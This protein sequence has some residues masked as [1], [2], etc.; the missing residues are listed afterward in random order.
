MSTPTG[1]FS[2]ELAIDGGVPVR[3][4]PLP[5][6]V[7]VLDSSRAAIAELLERGT[8]SDWRGGPRVRDFEATFARLHGI[9]FHCVAVNSGTSALHLACAALRIGPGDE[10][11]IP[12][13]AYVSAASAVAQVGGVPIV[14]DVDPKTLT[15]D[16]EDA[17]RRIT[18]RTRALLPVHFWGCPSDMMAIMRLADEHGLAVI[19]DCGQSHGALAN[20]RIVGS[21]GHVSCYSFAPRKHI[22]TGQGGAVVTPNSKLARIVGD[23]A[24]KGKG[25]GWLDYRELGFS[26]V[27]PEFEAVLALNGI[28]LLDNE[29]RSRRRAAAI[30]RRELDGSKLKIWD[31]PPWGEHVYFKMPFALPAEHRDA[32]PWIIRAIQAEN[33]NCRP[34]HPP[35]SSIPWLQQYVAGTGQHLSFD[36]QPHAYA[37]L[38]LVFEV[39]TGPGMTEDDILDSARAIRKVISRLRGR[40][41]P[42]LT[43]SG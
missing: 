38:P 33:V 23:L 5:P 9:D 16:L 30:Y 8:F 20:D 27:M 29:I 6:R 22:S 34:T 36:D 3:P 37:V 12:C 18:P 40:A 14:C 19:E 39:E 31:D 28:A 13:A 21:Y 15:M 41:R 17:A 42:Q 4:S 24:N 2:T 32:L 7:T 25:L 43:P 35:L 1:D 26:Y 11:I 10:V